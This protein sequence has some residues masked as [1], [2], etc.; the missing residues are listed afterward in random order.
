MRTTV[1]GGDV[2]PFSSTKAILYNSFFQPYLPVFNNI[3]PTVAWPL[4]ALL[5]DVFF[6]V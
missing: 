5:G 4:S 2:P 6:G 3:N 1:R